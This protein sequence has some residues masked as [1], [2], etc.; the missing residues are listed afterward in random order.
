MLKQQVGPKPRIGPAPALHRDIRILFNRFLP[1]NFFAGDVDPFMVTT[2]VN[3]TSLYPLLH[4]LS[5]LLETLGFELRQIGDE[6]A[7]RQ[8]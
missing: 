6:D 4:E 7:T 5:S 1:A 2:G 8:E 3:I